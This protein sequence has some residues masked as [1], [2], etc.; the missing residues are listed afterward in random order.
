MEKILNILKQ[1]TR[2][3]YENF[4][5]RIFHLLKRE[6][7]AESPNWYNNNDF[8]NIINILVC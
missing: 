5:R 6:F 1:N 3:H 4:R 8:K 2:M 7:Y